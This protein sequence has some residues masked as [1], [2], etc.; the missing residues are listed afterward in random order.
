M[1]LHLKKMV[2]TE[3]SKTDTKMQMSKEY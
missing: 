2:S 1:A 3:F